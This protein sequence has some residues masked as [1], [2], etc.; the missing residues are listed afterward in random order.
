MARPARPQ[1]PR[2]RAIIALAWL[3]AGAVVGATPAAAADPVVM[4]AG[5]IACPS[6]GS[7]SAGLCSDLYTSNLARTQKSSASG[8]A[9]LLAVGD[10]QY[11]DSTVAEYASGF[12]RS[13][14]AADLRSVLRPVPG[15][16]EYD[17]A[18]APGYFQYFSSIGVGAGESGKGWYSYN[19]GAWH[20]VALNSSDGCQV[21]SC[22]AGS[23][24]ETWLKADLAASS[25]PCQ[26]VYWHHPLST[27]PAEVPIWQDLYA[28]GVDFVVTGHVHGY[29]P[30]RGLDPSGRPDANGPREAIVGTGGKDGGV[31]GLLKLTLHPNSADWSFVGTTSNSGSATCRAVAPPPPPAPPPPSKPDSAF[32]AAVSGLTATFSDTSTNGPTGWVWDFGDG[33][34]IAA[35]GDP[36]PN[37][38]H[39]Y[40]SAGTYTVKL[41]ASNAGGA[42][43]TATRQVTVV[44]AVATRIVVRLTPAQARAAL[45]REV[46]KRLRHWKIT[47]ITCRPTKNARQARCTFRARR[48]ARTARGS[49]TVTAL[50]A[51]SGSFRLKVRI[52]GHRPR[53]WKGRT[54]V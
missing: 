29:T 49:G 48:H 13:W 24:Q 44:S 9:A 34:G 30:P 43:T 42:G 52:S 35:G 47:R 33:S 46:G 11:E 17:I 36:S 39:T 26:L 27:A 31:Y 21:V 8:L 45:R 23:E 15:N 22:A 14:G 4:A 41:T 40:A 6:A 51:A 37:P 20:V 2:H 50:S 28:A 18:G 19:I 7:A 53:V 38:S 10:T 25:Q 16:H 32:N 1:R 5:D 54:K 12:N 3:I